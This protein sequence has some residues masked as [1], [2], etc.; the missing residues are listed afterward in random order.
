MQAECDK[1]KTKISARVRKRR[2]RELDWG[3]GTDKLHETGRSWK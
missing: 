1:K 3:K 2:G